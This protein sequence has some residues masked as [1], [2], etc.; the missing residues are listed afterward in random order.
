MTEDRITRL[1]IS[2][3][4]LQVNNAR[5][6]AVLES[7]DATVKDLKVVVEELRDAASQGKGALW[8][9]GLAAAGLGTVGGGIISFIVK[10]VFG[11]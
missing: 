9:F 6:G 11:G 4:E 8:A 5:T 10:K 7:L 3:V 1:E 2:V